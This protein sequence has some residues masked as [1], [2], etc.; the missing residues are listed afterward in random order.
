M[1][2]CVKFYPRDSNP[3]PCPPHPTSTYIC[4]VT[5][6]PM[7]ARWLLIIFN[8]FVLYLNVDILS[9]YDKICKIIIINH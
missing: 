5:T 9:L 6:A 4:E 7:G 2:L 8:Y 1:Y 3:D